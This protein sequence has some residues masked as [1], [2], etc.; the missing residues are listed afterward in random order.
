MAI[1]NPYVP[2]DPYSYDLKWIVDEVKQAIELYTPLHDEFA[3]VQEAFNDLYEY[4]HNYFSSDVF[5][6]QLD[7]A[8]RV[9]ADDG[10]LSA[11]IQPL[12]DTYE[13]QIDGVIEQFK[14]DVN[15]QLD[16]QDSDIATLVARMDTFASLPPGSTA[17]NAELLDIRVGNRGETFAS[18]GDAVREQVDETQ[19]LI[20]YISGTRKKN[21]LPENIW[22]DQMTSGVT[23]TTHQDGTVDAIGTATSNS[24]EQYDMLLAPGKYV[25]NGCPNGGSSATYSILVV[26]DGNHYLTNEAAEYAFELASSTTITIYLRVAI[27]TDISGGITF[28]PMVRRDDGSDAS[29]VPPYYPDIRETLITLGDN[30]VDNPTFNSMVGFNRPNFIEQQFTSRVLAGLTFTLNADGSTSVS[31]TATSTSGYTI[32]AYLPAGSYRFTGI[33]GGDSMQYFFRLVRADATYVDILDDGQNGIGYLITVTDPVEKINIS[34]RYVSGT[35]INTVIHPMFRDA[36]IWDNTFAPY[37]E[38]AIATDLKGMINFSPWNWAH[39]KMN[40]FG[41]SIVKGSNGNFVNVIGWILNLGAARNYGVGGS[42]IASRGAATDAAYPPVVLEYVNGDLDADL[43]VV[44]AGT[45]D[46]TSQVPIGAVNSTDITT[47]NGALNVLI[48]GLKSRWPAKMIVISNILDR[49]NDD[50]PSFP[51]K[52]QQYRDALEAA[53]AR[54]HVLFF[55]GFTETYLDMK[56]AGSPYTN[57]GLH[58]N[59]T[60][61]NILGRAMA[62]YIN[63]H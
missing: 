33:E 37:G 6:G 47:F 8:L 11:L 25:V 44:H 22:T 20:E 5:E 26:H 2:G 45:N 15:D 16:D 52:C 46:Y 17:G 49:V 32:A 38:Y 18:A 58:P 12:F 55:N 23:W 29:Y 61:A 13:G 4:V 59:Q 62:G 51:I 21:I 53:A 27:N 42:S 48:D 24:F 34:F 57:D 54:H 9:L 41:D 30:F 40:A 1:N 3:D 14:L 63:T 56:M 43:I 60:G 10:T 50:T 31:G 7:A 19:D 35:T 36:A 39:K 28:R